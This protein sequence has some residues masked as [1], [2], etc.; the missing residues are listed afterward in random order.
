M[1][2]ALV[3]VLLAAGLGLS[4]ACATEQPVGCQKDTD[5]AEGRICEAGAC[6][7]SEASAPTCKETG[8]TCSVNGDCCNFQGGDGYCVSGNCADACSMGTDCLSGCCA[9]L[10]SGQRA[11]APVEI[12]SQPCVDSGQSCS[13]NGD[14][15]NYR[16][17]H[18]F[19]VD[20]ICADSCEMSTPEECFSGCCA[21]L[22]GGDYA[23]APPEVCF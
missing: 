15:C 8:E 5:C 22:Q 16:D 4:G 13:V 18:G 21:E 2:R 1:K 10:A 6:T 3:V 17:G 9:P 20:G 19:C 23:C 14:C 11:C 12:C 7:W